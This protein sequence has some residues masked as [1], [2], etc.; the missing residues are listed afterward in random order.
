[1]KVIPPGDDVCATPDAVLED[2]PHDRYCDLVM[3]GGVASGVVYPWAI[4]ELARAFRF[5]NIGGTSVG[6]M[7]AVL[8]AA[9]EYGRRM[10]HT[11]AFE[12]LRRTPAALG[13]PLPDGRT[14]MFSLFQPN[15]HGQR[16]IRWWGRV[17]NGRPDGGT[18]AGVPGVSAGLFGRAAVELVRVYARPCTLGAAVGALIALGL[19]AWP[20]PPAPTPAALALLLLAVGVGALLGLLIALGL[21]IVRGVIGNRYGLCAGGTVE[22]PDQGEPRP[23]L[24]EWLHDGIQTSAGLTRDDPPLTFRDLW[25]APRKPGAPLGR[26][27]ERDPASERAINLQ[28]ITTSLTHGRPYR[29]PMQDQTSRLFFRPQ[30]WEPYFPADVMAALLRVARPYRP[31]EGSDPDP[32]PGTDGWRELPGADLPIVVAARLS[33][34]FPILFSA[35]PLG[36]IDY[37]APKRQRVI[38]T[39]L[40]SDGGISSNF[41]I[42]LFDGAVPRWPT[43]GLWL[44]RRRPR[45]YANPQ[46]PEK[47]A[48]F[49]PTFLNEGWGDSW[50]RFD[51][52]SQADTP[53]PPSTRTGRWIRRVTAPFGQLLGFAKAVGASATDWQDRTTMR[54]PHMRN[55]V[56]RLCLHD[57]EGGLH[58]A[59]SRRQILDMAATYGTPAGRQMVD[60]FASEADHCPSHWSQHRWVRLQVLVAS[61]HD[62][63]SDLRSRVAWEAHS[64]ALRE[65]V[66]AAVDGKPLLGSRPQRKVDEQH[67]AALLAV[68]DS[69]A[70]LQRQLAETQPQ[71]FDGRPAPELRLR[72]PL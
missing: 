34:S 47:E 62:M 50:D 4:V 22:A 33:L 16:L 66:E 6:A 12:V 65:I 28:V 30:E 9:A 59:M 67:A 42:H 31:V 21:D 49:F 71:P 46:R 17:F 11:E 54:L 58:I 53:G 36:A 8:A 72:A 19:S 29:L 25:N 18:D 60:R 24:V 1:M 41:P 55:R 61:L 35:V 26:C 5:R 39:C 23:A 14:R 27:G 51:P 37:E 48:I 40:F 43:F 68:L 32:G 10:G 69:L 63:V 45:A 44:D 13:E 3:T 15:R 57:H 56:A 38:R 52:A 70:Q 20:W 7:A 2:P 64:P